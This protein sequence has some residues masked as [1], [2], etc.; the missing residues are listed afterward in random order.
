MNHTTL[1]QDL[2]DWCENE[3][4][5]FSS[6]IDTFIEIAQRRL[7]RELD[8]RAQEEHEQTTLST[9]VEFLT[10]PS[11]CRV[12]KSLNIVVDS[13]RKL[14][15]QK[16]DEWI[17]DYWPNRDTN[18][19]PKYWSWWDQN[20]IIIVPTPDDTYTIEMDFV[21]LLPALTSGTNWFTANAPDALLY[22]CLVEAYL[23]EKNPEM[24]AAMERR[25]Q[26]ALA[27]LKNEGRRQRRDDLRV[28]TNPQGAENTLT[29]SK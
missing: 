1:T 24:S 5:E 20:E 21:K 28:P 4:S 25:L 3:S 14:L 12:I 26:M 16:T 22:A 13:S 9:G 19:E 6:E 11:D 27:E 15:I 29:G 2:K 23:F 7:E 10:I 18:G 8:V 17:T